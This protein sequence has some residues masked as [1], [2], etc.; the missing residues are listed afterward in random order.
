MRFASAGRNDVSDNDAIL[1]S[2]DY[3]LVQS[4]AARRHLKI[5]NSRHVKP[6]IWQKAGERLK[7]SRRGNLIVLHC[8]IILSLQN[9]I[10]REIIGGIRLPALPGGEEIDDNK[11]GGAKRDY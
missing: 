11:R 5:L 1:L 4:S 10:S 2:L 3:K 7:K 8:S 6:I 9:K